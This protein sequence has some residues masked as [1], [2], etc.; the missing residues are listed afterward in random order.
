MRKVLF[1][2]RTVW[3]PTALG[4]CCFVLPPLLVL[5][6]WMI[7]GE[8]FLSLTRRV[9]ADTLVVE[10]WIG[11]ESLPKAKKE[12]EQGGYKYLVITGGLTGQTWSQHRESVTE[13]AERDLTRMGFPRE[14]LVLAPCADVE[15]QRTYESA[16]AA[17]RKMDADG[18]NSNGINVMSRGAHARRTY[19]V[20][21]KVFPEI[22]VGSISWD[23]YSTEESW[24][25]SSSRAKE[26]LDETFGYSYEALFS[27][28][29]P[30]GILKARILLAGIVGVF[31]LLLFRHFKIRRR[32][33]QRLEMANPSAIKD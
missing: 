1:Q 28:G 29:R 30:D 16:V 20:Y 24:W 12:Y 14:K 23:P 5:G 6:F 33:K 31:V 26:L 25:R 32:I 4:W 19:L 22:K 27:T 21:C 15:K 9:P 10:G 17:K 13:I 18:L 3:W 2:R 7:W 8:A 11:R